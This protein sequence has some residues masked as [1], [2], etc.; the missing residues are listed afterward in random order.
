MRKFIALTAVA[1][2]LL[3]SQLASYA[4]DS[5]GALAIIVT[6]RRHLQPCYFP[7]FPKLLNNFYD[8]GLRM[9]WGFYFPESIAS[10]Q[11]ASRLEPDNPMP[12]FGL[13]HAASPNP[14]SRYQGLPDDPQGAGLAAIRKALELI[15]N[16]SQVEREMINGLF[17]LYNKDAIPDN[18]ERDFAFLDAMRNLHA[19]FPDD[20]DI[21]AMF[22]ESYMN[23]TQWDYWGLDGAAKGGTA[24]AQA[25]LEAAMRSEHDHPG[26]NHLYIHLMEASAQP[27][28]GDAGGA[29]IG[30]Y[31]AYFRSYGTYAWSHLPA[32]G[33][34]REGHRHQR[35]I[36]DSRPA[37]CRNLG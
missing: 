15:N 25:A 37:V 11:E 20:A 17:V 29:E 3:V 5:D 9:A 35:A 23:T 19:K 10:Y 36:T 34:I 16:G 33:R 12:Y 14:N 31:L 6:G 13:A 22:A 28:L 26:A 27:E 4:Q 7:R 1:T 18:R 30:G 24:E 32:G 8:Q 2:A 21:G